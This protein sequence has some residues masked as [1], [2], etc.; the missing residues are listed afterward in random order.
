MEVE[1]DNIGIAATYRM[2]ATY[3]KIS[4]DVLAKD[5]ISNKIRISGN[6]KAIP[7]YYMISHALELLLKCALLKRNFP[8]SKLKNSTLRHNL[9]GLLDELKNFGIP[10]TED[11]YNTIQIISD[12]HKKHRLRY[13]FLFDDGLLTFTPEPNSLNST[14]DELLLTGAISTFGK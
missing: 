7:Y 13:D 1:Y 4:A 2:T 11:T 14:Y 5:F 9:I 3:F 12:Q 10:I 6:R 8:K